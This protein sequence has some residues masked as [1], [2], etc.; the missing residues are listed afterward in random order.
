MPI[1]STTSRSLL[2]QQDNFLNC[3][4][5][6]L[7]DIRE[8]QRVHGE[9]VKIYFYNRKTFHSVLLQAVVKSDGTFTNISVGHSGCWHDARVI[10]ESMLGQNGSRHC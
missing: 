8:K 10:Q 4:L 7:E 5:Y 3:V 6:L 9:A 2:P 1:A